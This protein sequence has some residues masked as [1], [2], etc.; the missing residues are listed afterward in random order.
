MIPHKLVCVKDFITKDIC[1]Q[2]IAQFVLYTKYKFTYLKKGNPYNSGIALF[3][4]PAD[5]YVCIDRP[6]I[7]DDGSI[8]TATVLDSGGQLQAM[9]PFRG[10]VL[11]IDV[12]DLTPGIYFVRISEGKRVVTSKLVRH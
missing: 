5:S 8:L 10:P 4:N 6:V 12:S 7:F 2:N 1:G 11:R 9:L 3:P